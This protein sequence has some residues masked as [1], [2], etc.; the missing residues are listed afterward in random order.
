MTTL[1]KMVRWLFRSHDEPA[2]G[3]Y[4]EVADQYDAF[5]SVW[6]LLAG[7]RTER[8]M[9]ADLGP[10]LVPG[11]RVL[12]AGCGTGG[13]TRRLLQ[14][15][16]DLDLYVL[17]ASEGMLAHAES[18]DVKATLGSIEQMPF[19]DGY[20]D[21]VGSAW[22]IETL[23]DANAAL[24]EL[25]R[26]CS[27]NGRIAVTFCSMPIGRFARLLTSPLRWVIRTRFS[28]AFLDISSL[29]IPADIPLHIETH[30]LGLSTLVTLHPTTSGD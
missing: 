25:T 7:S 23:P 1:F 24:A 15:Q 3:V 14:L 4:T 5:R 8:A 29:D 12:D 10:H 20:F 6:L 27:P 19:E 26:V 9:L 21:V 22:V 2:P 16:P 13:L 11:A 28:G 18:L 30:H 17:D